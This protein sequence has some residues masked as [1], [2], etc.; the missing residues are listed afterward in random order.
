MTHGFALQQIPSNGITLNAAVEGD[1]PLVIMV[2]GWP[3][4]W[5]SW[6]HQI[7]PIAQA[8]YRV[9]AIDVRGYGGSD[10][11][12][13]VDAYGM[14]PLTDDVIGVIDHFGEERAI[15][16]GHD[17]GAPICWNTTALHPDR[18]AAVAGLS[19]PYSRRGPVSGLEMSHVL[20]KDKFF[21]HH[22]FQ[23]EGVVEAELEADPR[24]SLRKIYFSL[25]GDAAS[26]DPWLNRPK[27]GGLLDALEDPEVFPE[28]MSDADLDYYTQNF[29]QSGFRGA[30]NRYRN[31]Q[32]DYDNLPDIGTNRIKP[33][34]CFIGGG[35]DAV[36]GFIPGHDMYANA[37]ALCDDMRLS[38]VIDGKGHWI[39][40]E[41]AE[42]VTALLLE[43][44]KSL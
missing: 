13:A 31:M 30:I 42:E 26:T 15:L 28:W 14:G 20:Y 5:Y 1:G 3:E 9:V 43:F 35:K 29:A 16:F 40:Q 23:P 27:G 7:R 19:V 24:L 34:A 41:A 32:A 12:D 39:Q 8:G 11:P 10:K 37:G 17:W 2:H 44:L 21:Y 4:L 25:S 38:K 22:Y 6:R 33:P 36:R 18:V